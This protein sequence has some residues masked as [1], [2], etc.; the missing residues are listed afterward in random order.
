MWGKLV[1]QFFYRNDYSNLILRKTKSFNKSRYSR[2]RQYYRTGVYWCLWLNIIL[3]FALYYVF[4]RYTFK[5][6]YIFIF[7][8]VSS[9]LC[10]LSFFSKNYFLGFTKAIIRLCEPVAFTIILE[11]M[12]FKAK[13]H[14]GWHRV[15]VLALKGLERSMW[16]KKW[17]R[18]LLSYYTQFWGPI[19][20]YRR[21]YPK[22]SHGSKSRPAW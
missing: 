15:V 10:L 8:V 12:I 5:F 22:N 9:I 3:V 18:D 1:K 7:Y 19:H 6:S 11:C 13:A 14:I 21:R 16:R 2:N 4:Y 17:F 20:Y